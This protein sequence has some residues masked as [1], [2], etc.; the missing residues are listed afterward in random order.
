MSSIPSVATYNERVKLR[1]N[2]LDRAS[3]ASIAV[4]LFAPLTAFFLGQAP[5]SAWQAVPFLGWLATAALLHYG[6]YRYLGAMR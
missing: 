4:G 2:A 3:T 5:L 6:A 1:A